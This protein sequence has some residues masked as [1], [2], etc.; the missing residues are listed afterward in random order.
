M[1]GRLPRVETPSYWIDKGLEDR[2]KYIHKRLGSK[3]KRSFIGSETLDLQV[4]STFYVYC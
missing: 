4:S 2:D 3:K 1:Q